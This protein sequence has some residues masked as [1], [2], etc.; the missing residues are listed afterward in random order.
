M[1]VPASTSGVILLN[2]PLDMSSNQAL[3]KVRKLFNRCKAGHT[4]SLD[5]KATGMLPIC[6]NQATKFA[7]FLLSAD[8]EYL[9]KAHLGY[10]SSTGDIEGELSKYNSPDVNPE[11]VATVLKTFMGD[12]KQ[13]PPMFSALKHQGRPWYYYALKGIEIPREARSVTI[14]TLTLLKMSQ[15]YLTLRVVCSKGTYIRSLVAD[16]GQALGCGAY[17]S[18]LHRLRV[19]PFMDQPM[20]S[21][22]Q[23][24]NLQ[25]LQ[26]KLLTD[27]VIPIA[28]ILEPMPRVI[29]SQAQ[30]EEILHG[31]KISWSKND[32]VG[33][34]KLITTARVFLGI[35]V[36]GQDSY[37][38]PKRLMHS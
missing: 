9:V 35:G 23:M 26:P 21:L 30:A 14:K 31:R 22:T 2:K 28:D 17:V 27:Q 7:S 15:E 16:I 8:K 24:Q 4:G 37:L 1:L 18:M 20:L 11:K 32:D 12:I 38:K 10:T 6:L 29:L 33:T 5:P 36:I 13:L 34:V 19:D 25:Q 3:Q